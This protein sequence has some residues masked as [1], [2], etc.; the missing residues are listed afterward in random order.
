MLEVSELRKVDKVMELYE[1][2][3]KWEWRFGETPQFSNVLEKKF[4]WDLMDVEFDVNKG[5]ITKAK[6][7][8]DC[9]IPTFID[10]MNEILGSGEINYDT[11]GMEE[12]GTRLFNK[13]SDN[14]VIV[15]KMVPEL[16]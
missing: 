7:Y 2:Y 14:D 3:K 11:N 4:D 10:E 12:L 9:L 5:K 1:N 6:V 8:S 16:I 13:F 15:T